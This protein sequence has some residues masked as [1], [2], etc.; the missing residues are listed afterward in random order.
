M[1]RKERRAGQKQ[2]N[3]PRPARAA[4]AGPA[5]ALVTAA[6]H[7]FRSGQ[8]A[9]A[10]RACR[11]ALAFDPN[12][13]DA[14]HLLGVIALRFGNNEAALDLLGKAIALNDRDS[15]SRLNI[16]LVFAALGRCDKAVAQ[17]T[18]AIDLNPTS[19]P[20]LTCLGNVLK[21]QGRLDEAAAQY[22]RALA[23]KPDAMVHYNLGN[24]LSAQG[25]LAEAG[26]ISAGARAP[27]ELRRYSQ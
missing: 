10:E 1:S 25:E 18:R 21:Q 4:P 12:H 5:N 26:A 17:F 9:E 3:M 2:G 23:V 13:F 6:V 14:L 22:R 7:H 16:G 24:V 15:E 11:D 27:A 20:A 8:F 19:V